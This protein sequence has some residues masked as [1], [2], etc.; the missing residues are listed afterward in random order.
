MIRRLKSGRD[1]AVKIAL[2]SSVAMAVGLAFWFP[3]R[4]AEKNDIQQ[5]SSVLL[6]GVVADIT[7]EAQERMA[8]LVRLAEL[9]RIEAELSTKTRESQAKLFMKHHPGY[10]GL[11]YLDASLGVRWRAL[12]AEDDSSI[13]AITQNQPALESAIRQL[14]TGVHAQDDV[15]FTP[16]FVLPNRKISRRLVATI[17]GERGPDGFLVAAIDEK[18]SFAEIL[19]DQVNL[20]YAISIFDEE[21]REL[22]HSGRTGPEGYKDRG[23]VGQVRFAGAT[24]RV[25]VRPEPE[26]VRTLKSGLPELG[27]MLGSVIGLLVFCA[28]DLARASRS[29]SKQLGKTRDQLEARVRE[30]TAELESMNAKLEVEVNDRRQAEA[31]LRDLSS[32]LLKLKDEEQ[33]RIARELHDSTAQILGALAINL[34]RL[35]ASNDDPKAKKLLAESLDLLERATAE[36]RTISYL[37]HPPILDDLGLDGVLPWYANGFTNRSGIQVKLDMPPEFERL[38]RE[39]ELTLFRIVQEALTNILRHSGSPTAHIILF[40]NAADVRLIVQ[41]SGRGLPPEILAAVRNTRAV[42]GVGIAGM[43]ERVR[44]LGGILE[45]TSDSNGTTIDVTLP[46]EITK[47]FGQPILSPHPIQSESAS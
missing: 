32:G 17:H 18:A 45:I 28:F 29:R 9:F 34:E 6:R 30:R 44:Q 35:I 27:F 4:R 25:Q 10:V 23:Q 36:V 33:R 13:K 15:L 22:Y 16:A 46:I 2:M 19:K 41:D 40:R 43:R 12:A 38:A 3:L 11:E 37:L 31:S 20:G 26:L 42:V 39:L 8:A 7:D 47:S 21:N 24:W 14:M 1:L 5:F